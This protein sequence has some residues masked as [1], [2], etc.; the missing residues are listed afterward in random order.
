MEKG[1]N[2]CQNEEKMM[3]TRKV[4]VL[5]KNRKTFLSNSESQFH[6][7]ERKCKR[8]RSE[9]ILVSKWGAGR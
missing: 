4:C 5:E 9:T 2:S 3:R 8:S 6:V 1:H 7:L